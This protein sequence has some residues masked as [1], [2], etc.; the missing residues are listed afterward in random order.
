MLKFIKKKDIWNIIN[1]NDIPP[2]LLKRIYN[3]KTVQDI[4]AYDFLNKLENKVV[5]E[6]GGGNSRV[7]PLLSQNNT[8]FNIDKFLGVGNGPT[9]AKKEKYDIIDC[10]V[11]ESDGIINDNSF[12]YLFSVS[13]LEHIHHEKLNN[14]FGDCARIVRPNGVMVHLIDMYIGDYPQN[15]N[16]YL[17]SYLG[18]FNELFDPLSQIELSSPRDLVFSCEFATNPDNIMNEWNN[19]VPQLKHIRESQQSCSLI[20]A[21][22]CKKPN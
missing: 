9:K 18:A 6:C 15:E 7:L 5:A 13:V 10:Y 2:E 19:M 4:V 16:K 3:L 22:I 11:G 12:D 14:F 21:G 1:S 20:L 8:C 17:K